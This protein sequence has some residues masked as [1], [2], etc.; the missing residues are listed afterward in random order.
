MVSTLHAQIADLLLAIEQEMRA[1]GLWENS[2]PPPADLASRMPFCHDTLHFNQW[3]QWVFLRRMSELIET[4]AALPAACDIHPLAEH[5]FLELP[6]DTAR[7]LEL[8]ATID[9]TIC[10]R[11]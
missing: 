11:P 6:Q 10:P 9:R 3:L 7:L 1:I 5:S 2:P 8:I 4:G